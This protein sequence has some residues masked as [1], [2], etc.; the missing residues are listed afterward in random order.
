[1]N[2]G[3]VGRNQYVG[4]DGW[5]LESESEIG[6]KKMQMRLNADGGGSRISMQIFIGAHEEEARRPHIKQV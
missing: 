5:Y 6:N 4:N 1:M 3:L 2:T